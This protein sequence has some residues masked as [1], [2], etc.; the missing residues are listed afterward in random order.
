MNWLAPW[1][2]PVLAAG[3]TIPPLVVLYFLKLRR[4]QVPIAST[5][6]WRRAVEDLRV[7][8]PF[9]KLRNNLLLIL[10]LL[11]LLVAALALAE[12]VWRG[13]RAL[14]KAVVLIVDQS[15]SMATEE[16]DGRTRLAIAKR[17]CLDTIDELST[18]QRA[19]V[20]A[21]ADRAR[22][23]APLTDDKNALRRAV[24]SI[25]QTDAPGR[26]A[27]AMALAEAHSMPT[28]ENISMDTEAVMSH[29]LLFTDGRLSDAGEVVVKRGRLEV[30]RIGNATENIAI[31]DL[32]V[33]R[34]HERPEQLSILA[35]V[36]NL[37]SEKMSRD[38]LLLVDNQVKEIKPI[39]ELMPLGDRPRL[40]AMSTAEILSERPE[41]SEAT[42]AFDLILDS[43]A[44]IEL[45]LSGTDALPTDDRVF[46]V[47]TP[48]QP[49][50]VL[51]VTPG[52]RYLRGLVQALQNAGLI[53]HYELW[54][55][56]QYEEAPDAKLVEN[57]RSSYDVVILDG[58]STERLPPGNYFFFA[59]VPLIEG[60]DIGEAIE[61]EL[62][63]DWDET[64]PILRHVAVEAVNVIAWHKLALPV[65]AETLI[66]ATNG[67][68]LAFLTRG[69]NQYLICAFGFFNE[70]RTQLNTPWV[71][72]E[73]IVAFM[74]N[75]LGQLGGS[76]TIGQ[77]PSVP[78]GEPFTVAAK[79][80]QSSVTVR[81]PDGTTE[82]TPVRTSGFVS[83]SQ[84]DRV[85]IYTIST[86]L[87]G[88]D[89]RA[90]NLL[91]EAESFI[92][93]NENLQV[94]AGDVT[95]REGA[96]WTDRPLWP[97]LLAILTV[98]LFVEWF[99]Y[100]KQVFV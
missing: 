86:G 43:A 12:P 34:N 25:Q 14:E 1:Y 68:V 52:N 53:A 19:L 47:V 22:V 75:A 50:T 61:G 23:L 17:A 35:R 20:I 40:P 54:T 45:R 5:L 38:I 7:N 58:H 10:Q 95:T 41:G 56:E 6:L 24:E 21:F 84:A 27:D 32:D 72:Q 37:G 83:Y 79:P 74:Q 2:I 26:L 88:E 9:Q 92:A 97:H 66:E 11:I 96:G 69:R 4:Q 44:Q 65:E 48:L 55:P 90:V 82:D 39:R 76:T 33:R 63:L 18:D 8:A 99:V 85:G 87:K 31:V 94:A 81:R 13:S 29:Y 16:N 59:S 67:P 89:A 80:N 15:A 51:V 93:P 100:T 77:I 30:I 62:F 78:P 42:V 3:L 49:M 73:S 36:R 98:L 91:N 28:G 64:H 70:S 57:G 60:V 46:S 71:F